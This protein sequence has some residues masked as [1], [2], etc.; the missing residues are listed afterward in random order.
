MSNMESFYANPL[1]LKNVLVEGMKLGKEEG[2]VTDEELTHLME[3]LEHDPTQKG[4]AKPDVP[5]GLRG[6]GGSGELKI[7]PP[8]SAP[9]VA[10]EETPTTP[11]STSKKGKKKQ[12]KEEKEKSP[13][14]EE[15]RKDSEDLEKK[16]EEVPEETKVPSRVPTPSPEEED[17]WEEPQNPGIGAD[18]EEGDVTNQSTK[19]SSYVSVERGDSVG[20]LREYMETQ[21]QSLM[22]ILTPLMS[23]V[24]T[25]ERKA[26]TRAP[27]VPLSP[28][29]PRLRSEEGGSTHVRRRSGGVGP[30]RASSTVEISIDD[31]KAYLAKNP[32]YPSMSRV[33][34]SKLKVLQTSLGLDPLPLEVKASDW[35][36]EGLYSLLVT[37]HHQEAS[38]S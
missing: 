14:K 6:E 9:V 22:Q 24:E 18:V 12:K 15:E 16:E 19:S 23:R 31:V 37:A 25:L 33:R 13:K 4:V 2:A 30:V 17:Q 35:S 26:S 28:S 38:P 11:K 27:F 1:E 5:R 10:P 3:K 34:E 32:M 7:Q 36:K 29:P 8:K 21:F 20:D